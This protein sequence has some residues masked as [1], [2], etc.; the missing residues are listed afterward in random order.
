MKSKPDGYNALELIFEQ[1]HREATEFQKSLLL[2]DGNKA[3]LST[4][5]DK[6]ET[7]TFSTEKEKGDALETLT[8]ETL[9]MLKFFDALPNI[10]T[11]TNE[12]DFLCKLSTS[13]T[14]AKAK[15][16]FNFEDDFLIECKNY[17]R[18][19]DVTYVGKF[20][21]LLISQNKSFGI[22][23][24]KRGITGSNWSDA[25]GW[26]KKLFLKCNVLIISFTMNDFRELINN[27]SF[28]EIIEQKKTDIIN[29]T[30]INGHLKKHP[31]MEYSPPQ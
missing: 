7:E 19:V 4:L 25:Y 27:K 26:T 12:I 24:S 28:F 22:L 23:V 10:H 30:D 13:G 16:Y 14:I 5:I 3:L 31:A 17:A 1:C 20:A 8:R 18:P 2:N 29:D 21:C 11:S 9:K 6:I 15:G